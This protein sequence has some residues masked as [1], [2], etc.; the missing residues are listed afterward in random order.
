[1]PASLVLHDNARTAELIEKIWDKYGKLIRV[2]RERRNVVLN[3]I[4]ERPY[5]ILV[6][7]K[8]IRTIEKFDV[9]KRG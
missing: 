2:E 7:L 1:M 6:F 8:G 4:E 5:C 3:S 9:D